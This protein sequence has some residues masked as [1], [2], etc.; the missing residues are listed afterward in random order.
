[1]LNPYRV[2]VRNGVW[3]RVLASA[4]LRPTDRQLSQAGTNPLARQ[5][6]HYAGSRSWSAGTS[7]GGA[8]E[9][10]VAVERKGLSR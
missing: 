2:V 5:Y 3:V 9:G 10:V 8:R 4:V 1:M 7:V 6:P